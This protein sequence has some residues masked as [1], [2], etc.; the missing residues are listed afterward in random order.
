[1]AERIEA[2]QDP[3][4]ELMTGWLEKWGRP[5]E[6]SGYMG[7]MDHGSGDPGGMGMDGMGTDGMGMTA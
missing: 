2:G 3:E 1:M 6:E 4:I 7:G 5:L